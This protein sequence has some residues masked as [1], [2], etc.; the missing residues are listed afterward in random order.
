[1][2]LSNE[3]ILCTYGAL[4]ERE[5]ARS[6]WLCRDVSLEKILNV[7]GRNLR[8]PRSRFVNGRNGV[9]K[10]TTSRL[11]RIRTSRRLRRP[12]DLNPRLKKGWRI[13]TGAPGWRALG[14]R[15]SRVQG[16]RRRCCPGDDRGGIRSHGSVGNPAYES[17]D[18]SARNMEMTMRERTTEIAIRFPQG[19]KRILKSMEKNSPVLDVSGMWAW[20]GALGAALRCTANAPRCM[21]WF[22][23]G[24]SWSA[25]WT[26]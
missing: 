20:T 6:E 16:G 11:N 15:Q 13:S 4:H 3:E 24:A 14:V 2:T 1:M 23:S 17:A 18:S 25:S 9:L 8:A 5:R 22:R 26:A 21:T 12:S 7:T 10:G 19:Y